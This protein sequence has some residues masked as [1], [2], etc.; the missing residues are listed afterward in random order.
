MCERLAKAR[1]EKT[2]DDIEA[3]LGYIEHHGSLDYAQHVAETKARQGLVLLRD[4]FAEVPGRAAA[5]ELL[6]LLDSVA[7]RRQ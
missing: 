3:I 1:G 4:L 5:D 2:N 7:R 6:T